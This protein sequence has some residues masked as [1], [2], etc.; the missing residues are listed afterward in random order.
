MIDYKNRSL[1]KEI[2]DQNNI[3]FEDIVLNMKELEFINTHLG[4]HSIT[5]RGFQKLLEKRKEISVCE[6]GCG[7]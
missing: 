7:G 6:I 3:P 2:L 5:I 1:Q 4:G